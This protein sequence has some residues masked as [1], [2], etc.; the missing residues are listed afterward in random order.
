MA[1]KVLVVAMA[2]ELKQNVGGTVQCG[3]GTAKAC[4]QAVDVAHEHPNSEI[5]V[6]AGEAPDYGNIHMAQVMGH[7]ILSM[8]ATLPVRIGKA[9]VFDT[10]GEV[11]A[12]AKH[13]KCEQKHA[14]PDA[15]AKVIFVVK[16]WHAKR[17]EMIVQDIWEREGLIV[18]FETGTHPL[19]APRKVR[20]LEAPKRWVTPLIIAMR[21]LKVA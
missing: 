2:Y 18:P 9:T 3:F 4:A 10:I 5:F 20:W 7:Y 11:M 1:A 15:I 6:S 16:D 21:Y 14:G 17:V 12:T 8:T 19:A 13:V